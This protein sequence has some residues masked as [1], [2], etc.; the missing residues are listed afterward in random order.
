MNQETKDRLESVKVY[1]QSL[2]AKFLALQSQIDLLKSNDQE[3]ADKI[4]SLTAE[5]AGLQEEHTEIVT[6][7]NDLAALADAA[8]E[9]DGPE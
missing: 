7:A 1:L 3:D 6:V 5:V 9:A 2:P 4:A 8:N